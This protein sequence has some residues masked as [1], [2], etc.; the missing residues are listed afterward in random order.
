[1]K[2]YVNVNIPGYY[3]QLQQNLNW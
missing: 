1:M 2:L 3:T